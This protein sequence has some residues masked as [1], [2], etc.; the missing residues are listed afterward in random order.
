M[1]IVLSLLSAAVFCSSV[2][3]HDGPDPLAHWLFNQDAVVGDE[4]RAR[5]GPNGEIIGGLT[6]AEDEMG[7]SLRFR[8]GASVTI[9][10]AASV[11]AA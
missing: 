9:P 6:V 2:S 11:R 4:L 3:G 10:Q 1:R 7:E 8:R 5:L